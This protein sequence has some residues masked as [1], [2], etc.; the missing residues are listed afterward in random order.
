MSWKNKTEKHLSRKQFCAVK[1]SSFVIKYCVL[2]NNNV[3]GAQFFK[4][5]RLHSKLLLLWDFSIDHFLA[6]MFRYSTD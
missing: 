4:T 3:L 1:K 6:N 2:S 5:K